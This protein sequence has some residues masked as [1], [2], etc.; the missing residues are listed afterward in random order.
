MERSFDQLQDT[1]ETNR[2]MGKHQRMDNANVLERVAGHSS[3]SVSHTVR[4]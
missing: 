4:W 2:K 1:H 3:F